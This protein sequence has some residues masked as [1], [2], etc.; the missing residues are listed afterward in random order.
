MAWNGYGLSFWRCR[1]GAA[2]K[3]R[4]FTLNG[5]E[6]IVAV[7]CD[8]CKRCGTTDAPTGWPSDPYAYVAER[9]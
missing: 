2:R 9:A 4:G 8:P 7:H 6:E 1:C 5:V 3:L